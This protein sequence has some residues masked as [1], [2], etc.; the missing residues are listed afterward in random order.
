[1]N[2]GSLILDGLKAM[3]LGM[4]WV[5]C[6]LSIM[7]VCMKVMSKALAPFSNFLEPVAPAPKKKKASGAKAA[8]S[9]EDRVRALAAIEAVK[10]Y[11][12]GK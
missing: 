10:L 6:F 9:P 8:L 2:L 3:A 5:F 4:L 11:R 1:M 12:A 7:I